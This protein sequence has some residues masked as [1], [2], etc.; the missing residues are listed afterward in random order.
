ML[1]GVLLLYT[2]NKHLLW[3]DN[4]MFENQNVILE[5]VTCFVSAVSAAI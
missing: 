4:V 5:T 2:V 3:S 1:I